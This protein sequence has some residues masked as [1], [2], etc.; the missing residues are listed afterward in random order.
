M[1]TAIAH[2]RFEWARV[3]ESARLDYEVTMRTAWSLPASEF[4]R[5]ADRLYADLHVADQVQRKAARMMEG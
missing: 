2:Q 3:M 5:Y 4:M 1:N